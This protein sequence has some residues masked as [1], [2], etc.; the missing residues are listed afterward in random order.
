MATRYKSN[1]ERVEARIDQLIQREL[2]A[3]AVTYERSLQESFRQPK[4]G[5][6]YRIGKTPTRADRR[7][8]RRFRSHRA[9][10][11]GEA[12]AIDTGA[13]S[14]GVTRVISRIGKMHF[15]VRVGM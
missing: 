9:S 4:S 6:I 1:R 5:R 15:T 12:P 10:A 7:A 14:K 11:P 13:L 8:G 3:A 2:I